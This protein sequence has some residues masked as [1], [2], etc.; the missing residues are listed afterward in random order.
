MI[1]RYREFIFSGLNPNLV[2][3]FEQTYYLSD[4]SFI[5]GSTAPSGATTLKSAVSNAY[6]SISY[7]FYDDDI[8]V[9]QTV[10]INVEHARDAATTA[11]QNKSA[12]S[13]LTYIA[14][15]NT[16]DDGRTTTRAT[17]STATTN[18]IIKYYNAS[19]VLSRSSNISYGFY[20]TPQAATVASATANTTT[21]RAS[22]PALMCRTSTTYESSAN[23]KK[24]MD[25]SW[26][27]N[28][29]VYTVDAFS[30]LLSELFNTMDEFLIDE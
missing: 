20:C 12:Y 8:I 22:S 30:S 16:S 14:K 28:V 19:G 4:T 13:F 2:D 1:V 24:V 26:T 23:M 29:K 25:V 17:M 6:T 15:R 11:K 3:E 27:W 18:N 7:P 5:N 9:V 21:V 10:N